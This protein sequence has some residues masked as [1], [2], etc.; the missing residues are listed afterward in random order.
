MLQKGP[1]PSTSSASTGE[2][3]GPGSATGAFHA[4]P[5]T[6]GS[7]AG[8]LET[9]NEMGGSGQRMGENISAGREGP[10]A[11]GVGRPVQTGGEEVMGGL[12]AN[13]GH[14]R[15]WVE[16]SARPGE[17]EERKMVDEE[18]NHV[19]SS[20]G[21]PITPRP[22][23]QKDFLHLGKSAAT[24][25]GG[26]FEGVIRD[27]LKAVSIPHSPDRRPRQQKWAFL[28]EKLRNLIV[29][30]FVKGTYDQRGVL[31][32][33]ERQ[34]VLSDVARLTLLNGSYLARDAARVLGKVRSLLPEVPAGAT[35]AGAAK[36]PQQQVKK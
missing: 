35:G 22:P 24:I 31:K 11:Q 15:N 10:N 25:A 7:D 19:R 20:K 36:R 6:P 34:P 18:K 26:N 29:K 27:R 23:Q 12:E 5:S 16:R 21:A 9:P 30:D 3:K 2:M 28:D 1:P 14:H 32:A 17:E 8:F 33:F 4:P 13:P